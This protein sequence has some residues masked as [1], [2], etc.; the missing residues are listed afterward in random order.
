M[1]GVAAP[2]CASGEEASDTDVDWE[3]EVGGRA[4]LCPSLWIAQCS[5]E[6]VVG[7]KLSLIVWR[8]LA[9]GA[10]LPN[11]DSKEF[12]DRYVRSADMRAAPKPAVGGSSKE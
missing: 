10:F 7:L 6:V 12:L 11:L 1:F 3:R 9:S 2:F 5:S 8:L 4:R